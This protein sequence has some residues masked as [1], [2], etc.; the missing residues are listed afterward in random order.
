MRESEVTLGTTWNRS[1]TS[2]TLE[3]PQEVGGAKA[4]FC[5]HPLKMCTHMHTPLTLLSCHKQGKNHSSDFLFMLT[6][7]FPNFS[8]YKVTK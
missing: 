5:E 7:V 6:N 8:Q 4:G 1:I 2:G 3:W